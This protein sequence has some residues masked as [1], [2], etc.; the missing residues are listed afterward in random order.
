MPLDTGETT[1]VP[2]AT[3]VPVT[4]IPGEIVVPTPLRPVTFS[5]VPAMLPK[6]AAFGV[7]VDKWIFGTRIFAPFGGM[8]PNAPALYIVV[9]AAVED[10]ERL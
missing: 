3:P 9:D 6:N 7:A 10:A 4:S 8:R 5:S 2:A 1:V